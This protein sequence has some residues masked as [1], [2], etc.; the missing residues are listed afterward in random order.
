LEPPS[1]VL[2]DYFSRGIAL[3]LILLVFALI[4]GIDYAF[5]AQNEPSSDMTGGKHLPEALM[6]FLL[7]FKIAV[8]ILSSSLLALIY[9]VPLAF[10]LML[11]TE[12]SAIHLISGRE[13]SYLKKCYPLIWFM[14]AITSPLSAFIARFSEVGEEE[15]EDRDAQE[16]EEMSEIIDEANIQGQEEKKMLKGIAALSN[17]SVYDIMR[18]RVEMVSLSTSMSS[19]QVMETAIECGYSRLPVYDGS[20]DNIKGF[21][22]IKDLVGY[23]RDGVSDFQWQRHI[24]RAYFVPGSKKISDLLEEFRQKKIHL[25]MVVDEYG[26]TDGVVTLEDVLEEIVGEIE[27]ESDKEDSEATIEQVSQ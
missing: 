7:L 10:T 25:A 3:I 11:A 23:L 27:D 15:K 12:S 13:K 6:L 1:S 18:P 19:R 21:L 4:S 24:R 16:F 20:P 8:I 14:C 26:G 9:A 22:Y 17:T 2:D 5:R